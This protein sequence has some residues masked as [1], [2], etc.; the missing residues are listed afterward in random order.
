VTEKSYYITT[1]IYYVNDVPHIGNAYTTIVSDVLARHQKQRGRKVVFATGTDEHAIKVADAAQAA[2]IPPKEFVDKLAAAFVDV[3]KSLHIDYDVFIRTTEPRH[4]KVVQKAFET[5]RERGD[6]YKG[7]YEG[8][9][10]VPDETF[11]REAELVDGKCPNPECRRPVQWVKEE[12]YYFKLSAYQ[13]RLLK[14]IEDNPDFLQPEFRKNE[15]VSFIKQ[16]L[17]DVS[18]TRASRGWGIAVPGEPD[19]FIY[20]WFDAL[21]NYITIAGW[22]EDEDKFRE[23]WPA[24]IELMGK[25]IFVRFHSTLWPAILMGLGLELPKVLFGHGFWSI[26]GQKISK[27]RGNAISPAALASD[28]AS[29]SGATTDIAIDAI[30]YFV[31]RE[32]PFGVDADFSVAALVGRFNSDLANDLGNLLNRT[33]SMLGRYEDNATIPKAYCKYSGLQLDDDVDLKAL[34]ATAATQAAEAF[35]KFQ[36]GRALDAIWDLVGAANRYLEHKAPWRLYKEGPPQPQLGQ[37]L[38]SVVETLRII[39]IMVAPFMPEAAK[40][41]WRQLGEEGPLDDQRWSDAVWREDMRKDVTVRAPA[42]VFPRIEDKARKETPVEEKQ[43]EPAKPEYLTYDEFK[44]VQLCIAEIK[45]AEK[46]PNADKLLK[47]TVDIGD[48]ERTIVAGIALYYEPDSLI[49]KKIVLLANLAPA[50]IRGV[51]SQGMLLAADIDG[52]AVILTPDSDVPPG[53]KIR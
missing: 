21:L 25:D 40:E 4:V 52:R 16:G 43:P 26:E 3:W 18:V 27:S 7:V 11:F 22:G 44:K 10:C 39:T 34:A 30:R 13:D 50:T 9:Y 31:L 45:T 37:V 20:V 28:L 5:L 17:Q 38:F 51:Q 8:W 53:S 14:H 2:G 33:L 49:G 23:I 24:D 36:F 15:V 12:N 47:L 6:I 42:P 41:I 46:V 29:Q 48:E 19:K 1:P 35:D 32:A